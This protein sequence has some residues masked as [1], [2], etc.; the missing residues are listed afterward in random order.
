[1]NNHYM[2]NIVKKM[3]QSYEFK[4]IGWALNFRVGLVSVASMTVTT[5]GWNGYEKSCAGRV[6]GI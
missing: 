6:L 3:G 2:V 5:Y 4:R 1:M